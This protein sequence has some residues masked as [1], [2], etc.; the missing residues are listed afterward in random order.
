MLI[1]KVGHKDMTS[2]EF[3]LPLRIVSRIDL[4]RLTRELEDLNDFLTQ[5]AVR[6]PGT[7]MNL[8]KLTS[9]LE[10]VAATN[11][12]SLLDKPARE[13]LSAVLQKLKNGAPEI[14]ISF[15]A[16]PPGPFVQK[17]LEW[18]RREVNPWVLLQIGLQPNIAAGCVLRTP[19]RYFD[20][21]LRRHFASNKA[22]LIERIRG[23]DQ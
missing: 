2:Q 12:I 4:N 7:P 13:Q 18:F 3:I 14:H 11:R 1:S 22:I 15:A 5:G 21:S 17:I 6:Q 20:L 23:T 10:E 16:D 9:L 19:N 8:P